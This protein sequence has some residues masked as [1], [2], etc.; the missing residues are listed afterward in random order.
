M[1]FTHL[2]VHTEYSLLDGSAKIPELVLRAKELGFD[3]L[4]ITDH[5]VMYGA[6]DFYKA[7]K[8]AG[9][10][11]IIGCEVYVAPGSRFDRENVKGEERYF[12]LIL[13][14]K[15]NLGYENLSKIVTRGFTEGFYY[16]PRVDMEVLET[17]HEDVICLSA[18]LAGEVAVHLRH[19]DYEGAK[20]AA[21]RYRGIFGEDY[22]LEMQDHGLPEQRVVN[23]GVMRL[24]EE[25]GI[26]MVVTNDSH[27]IKAEDAEPH[28]I[29]L[30]IQTQKT[31]DDPDRMRYEGGQ[32]YLKSEQEMAELFPYAKEALENTHKIA[33]QCNVNIIFHDQKLPKFDIPAEYPDS[34]AYLRALC[35]EGLKKRYENITDELKSRLDYEL[36]TIQTMGYVDYFL[37]VWDF[38]HFAKTH[39]IAVG[40]GRGSAAGSLVS[41][42][43]DITELDP[44]HYS[45]IFERFLNPERVSMPDID[46]D[47]MPEGRQAVIDYVTEKYGEDQVVQIVTFGTMKAKQVIKDVGRAYDMPYS[48]RDTISKMV[49]NELN[50]TL[51]DA[52][53]MSKELRDLYESDPQITK[54]IDMSMK[55][56]GLPRHASVHAAG[57]VIG[58]APIENY[59][60]LSKDSKSVVTTQYNMTTIEELGLLKMDFLG[61]RNLTVI[62]NAVKLV[63]QSKG[64][65]LDLA[66]LDM[67]DAKVYEM[68]GAGKT[69]GVF[70]LESSGMKGFMTELK[71]KNIEDIIAGISL[72]RPG[73]MDIIPM[74]LKAKANPETVSYAAPQLE[75]ILS[76][77]YGC[78]VYQEQVMQIVMELAGYSM[79][80]AD[81]V[82][83]A[84]SKKK[85]EVMDRE[86]KNFVFGNEEEGVPGCIAR[87][88]PEETANKI[89]DEMIDFAKYGFNKSH[90]ACYAIV[91]YQTAY[92]KCRYPVEYMAALMTS[93]KTNNSKVSAYIQTAKSMGI[94]ILP[95][96]VN[97]ATGDFSV[98][99]NAIRY[100]LSAIKSVGEGVTEAIEEDRYLHGPYKSLEDFATRM[101][102]KEANKRTLESL[103]C[104]G[105]FDN[106]G[107][108][109]RQLLMV[110]PL[111]LDQA[112]K[113][114]KN[115][116]SGQM[117][118]LDFMGEEEK[119]SFEIRYPN[120]ADFDKDEKYARE[121]EMTGVY[122][123]GHP[124]DD[125]RDVLSRVT[126][127]RSIDFV[128]EAADDE[129]EAAQESD[130]E[131]RVNDKAPYTVGGIIEDVTVK[132]TR[133]GDAM[134]FVT[135][136]DLY[137]TMEV[138]VFARDYDRIKS[139]LVKD[140]KVLISGNASVDDRGAKLLLSK[141]TSL[142]E[143]R[144]DYEAESKQ[145]WV[146][147]PDKAG[148]EKNEKK[149]IDILYEHPGKSVV[150][151]FL[152]AAETGAKPMVK[153]MPKN[154]RVTITDELIRKL[155]ATFGEEN[156]RLVEK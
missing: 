156:V 60:P 2:H 121:K 33:E 46:V 112:A 28:D 17:F 10:K 130:N 83:R 64:V 89:Y 96:D 19:G 73:P 37:I 91:A 126:T 82:R 146:R 101:S 55:L 31:V 106:F 129:A 137:G 39:G 18:C 42:C 20:E 63:E 102:N 53:K 115:A 150:Y 75:K 93:V 141:I 94:E 134:S 120:V 78:I 140:A 5:G 32:F 47:F 104:A 114:K 95:P 3:S 59:V 85:G 67:N 40:P 128:T 58:S 29:L 54:L 26:P 45:L 23:Q 108:N 133:R 86:R 100:G 136:E 44:I 38:I 111:I 148:F 71:P 87:G 56:E 24:H 131:N 123:S 8:N 98:D 113:D 36:S 50:I 68:I 77:T 142:D 139:M 9:I 127:A 69:E 149:L 151:A 144:S 90:A 119:K 118:L 117:S 125:Y 122:I 153:P 74:Y 4:A 154:R 27:Y 52:L 7:C 72:Y 97:L 43:L 66:H 107:Y 41:Y 12:H 61:L 80:R 76:P 105:A 16:K 25:L 81:L 13:L 143:A 132:I 30:C 15:S 116:I 65:K 92:L 103:I 135:I 1:S 34:A 70:Q 14:A 124:L 155:E 138:V 145:I 84:M 35:E 49:P 147:F 79:G 152:P 88:I 57:V 51:A 21:L 62:Q 22:Y 99:G 48:L 109:R 6:I 11:P 110:Y